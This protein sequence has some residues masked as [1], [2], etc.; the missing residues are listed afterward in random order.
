MLNLNHLVGSCYL[1]SDIHIM[2]Y[3]L[4]E[5]YVHFQVILDVA[6]E[7]LYNEIFTKVF[8]NSLFELSSHHCGNFAVQALVSNARCQAQVRVL[9]SNCILL[10]FV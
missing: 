3:D 4:T 8:R 1:F 9:A 7:T 10:P 2:N 6:P 5:F